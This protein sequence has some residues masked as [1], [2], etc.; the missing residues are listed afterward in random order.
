MAV[1][2]IGN[3]YI[4]IGKYDYIYHFV[5]GNALIFRQTQMLLLLLWSANKDGKIF[6]VITSDTDCWVQ[7]SRFDLQSLL[8]DDSAS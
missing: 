1:F 5:V 7:V 4:Y 6:L 8:W 3:I 2:Y